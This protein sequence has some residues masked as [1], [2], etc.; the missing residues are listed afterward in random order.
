MEMCRPQRGDRIEGN[1]IHSCIEQGRNGVVAEVCK[2]GPR[3]CQSD[4][5]CAACRNA[6][7]PKDS[8]SGRT[9]SVRVTL[10]QTIVI[11]I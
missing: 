2:I 3:A 6:V 4:R 1:D 10:C 11:P 7:P 5:S 8:A 9:D